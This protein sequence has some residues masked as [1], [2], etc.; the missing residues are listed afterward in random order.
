MSRSSSWRSISTSI[1]F[2]IAFREFRFFSSVL[3][4]SSLLPFGAME[5]FT[6][7]RI[8]PCS[9]L[10]SQIPAYCNSSMIFSR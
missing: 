7:Q 10:Q 5:M 3:V 2:A 4:P 8:E 1:A 9:I 6:S